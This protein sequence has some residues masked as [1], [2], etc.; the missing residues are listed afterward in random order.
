ML[1]DVI[2]TYGGYVFRLPNGSGKA[3]KTS[4]I[5]VIRNRVIL[6]TQFKFELGDEIT[7]LRAIQKARR[8]CDR[9]PIS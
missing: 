1:S 7:R 6:E 4:S 9:H 3:T 5:Q 2:E 8:W